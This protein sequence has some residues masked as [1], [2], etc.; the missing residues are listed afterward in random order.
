MWTVVGSLLLYFGARWL[1]NAASHAAW[2]FLAVA[3]I[4]GVIKAR[5][6]LRQTATRTVHRIRTRG[7]G[8]CIGGFLSV[9]TWLVVIAMAAA[10]RLLRGSPLPRAALGF[11]YAA[12]G[13]ALLLASTAI[14]RAWKHWP[15]DTSPPL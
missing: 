13:S 14:W 4:V 1:L 10:G 15:P 6:V 5:F 8:R 11:I 12:V 7:D 3:V 9:R 2:L